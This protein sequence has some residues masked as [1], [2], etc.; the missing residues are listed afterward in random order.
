MERTVDSISSTFPG[1]SCWLHE[2]YRTA[3]VIHSLFTD[4]H[5]TLIILRVG[6]CIEPE[7]A[8]PI[9]NGIQFPAITYRRVLDFKFEA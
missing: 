2:K 8:E 3:Q 1:S 9:P 6:R 7:P 5:T 4:N